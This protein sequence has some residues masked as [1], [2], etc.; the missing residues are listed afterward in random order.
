MEK[1]Y[2]SHWSDLLDVHCTS[3][4]SNPTSGLES[5]NSW[6][7]ALHDLQDERHMLLHRP[8]P[9]QGLI[10]RM[11][12]LIDWLIRWDRISYSKVAH[13]ICRTWALQCRV[14]NK[15]SLFFLFEH[16]KIMWWWFEIEQW[17]ILIKWSTEQ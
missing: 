4:S 14:F 16:F 1:H 5:S 2:I 6:L 8:Q 3:S 11:T 17:M 7:A 12:R 9:E 13:Q 15:F 10:E